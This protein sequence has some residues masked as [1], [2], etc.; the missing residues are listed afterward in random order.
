MDRLSTFKKKGNDSRRRIGATSR[1]CSS[2]RGAGIG[3]RGEKLNIAGFDN[4]PLGY[5]VSVQ[6]GDTRNDR[7]NLFVL[8]ILLGPT[9][10]HTQT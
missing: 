8:A 10:I 7:C 4:T 5:G 3:C 9:I 6:Q 2:R 1:G